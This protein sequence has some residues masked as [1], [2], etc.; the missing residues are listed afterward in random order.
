MAEYQ[1]TS[2]ISP[3][4]SHSA[5]FSY[6][7]YDFID[8]DSP[9]VTK[10]DHQKTRLNLVFNYAGSSGTSLLYHVNHFFTKDTNVGCVLWAY[11]D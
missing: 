10:F 4:P 2:S 8:R 5:D 9:F 3:G 7:F 11:E 1:G 6:H